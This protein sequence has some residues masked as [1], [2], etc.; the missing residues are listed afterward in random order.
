M[1]QT[2]ILNTLFPAILVG[3]HL[4]EKR[5]TASLLDRELK[6]IL[7]QKCGG[8]GYTKSSPSCYKTWLKCLGRGF[9]SASVA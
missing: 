2:F 5:K 9:K 1:E 7:C 6:N 3:A 4:T 8:N